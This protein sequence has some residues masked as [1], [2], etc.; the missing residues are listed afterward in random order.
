MADGHRFDE[1]RLTGA[2]HSLPL[3]SRVRV[4]DLRNQRSV[5]VTITD[6][7]PKRNRRIIDLSAAAAHSLGLIRQG[8][9]RVSIEI[10]HGH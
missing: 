1:H 4:T 9:G 10:V 2:S 7:M 6:R 8:T 5:V 3:G